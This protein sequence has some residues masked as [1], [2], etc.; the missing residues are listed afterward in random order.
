MIIYLHAYDAYGCVTKN[1]IRLS[2][3]KSV[4][5]FGFVTCLKF[6]ES[7]RVRNKH[8]KAINNIEKHRNWFGSVVP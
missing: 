5:T 8:D 2:I 7:Q 3:P 4:L 6:D 1:L